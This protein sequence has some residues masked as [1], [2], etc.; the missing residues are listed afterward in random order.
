MFYVFLKL[1]LHII[2]V[3]VFSV[4]FILVLVDFIVVVKVELGIKDVFEV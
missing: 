4:N 1:S 3:I 2:F